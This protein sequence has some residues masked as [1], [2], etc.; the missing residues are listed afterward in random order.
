M[1]PREI[2]NG[3][4]DLLNRL[5]GVERRVSRLESQGS[6]AGNAG[7]LTVHGNEYHDPDFATETA[8]TDHIN[9]TTTNHTLRGLG[10]YNDATPPTD[11]QVPTWDNAT[12]KWVPE[13]PSGG[14]GAGLSD[15]TPQPLGTAAAGDGTLASRDD[16]VHAMPSLLDLADTPN[17]YDNGKYLASTGS[18]T[19]WVSAPSGGT[20]TATESDS[21]P[22]ITATTIRFP[23]DTLDEPSSGV[24]RYRPKVPAIWVVGGTLV[25]GDEQGAL[26]P[27]DRD[28]A[29]IGVTIAAKGAPT[30]AAA[31]F[32][33]E[34]TSSLPGTWG[35]IFSTKP[36]LDDGSVTGG[37]GAVLGTTTLAEGGW[38]RFN[39]DQIGSTNAGNGVTFVLKMREI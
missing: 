21:T 12:S 22:S 34:H 33:V 23:K 2:V 1:Q 9:D 38:L 4:R 8:L 29:L 37:S 5:S 36:Q 3:F 31:I 19:Q 20:L 14:G 13:T 25:L 39:V 32:D 15:A 18:G 7:V 6:T 30:G 24:A 26:W 11:G 17:A 35:T 28:V 10:D 27:I 16:H